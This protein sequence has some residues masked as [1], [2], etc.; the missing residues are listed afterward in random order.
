MNA[1]SDLTHARISREVTL[2]KKQTGEH[3]GSHNHVLLEETPLTDCD[4]EWQP[5]Q[6]FKIKYMLEASNKP[7]NAYYRNLM[8]ESL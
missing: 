7:I 4:Y 2:K 5:A 3:S 8:L 6:I 1:I